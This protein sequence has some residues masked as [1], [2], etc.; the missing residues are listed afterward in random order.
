MRREGTNM[1]DQADVSKSGVSRSVE[2]DPGADQDDPK[3]LSR[4][5]HYGLQPALLFLVIGYWYLNPDSPIVYPLAL[6]FIQF[7]L[8]A[9]EYWR[10]ARPDW[11]HGAGEKV[12]NVA[13]VVLLTF[14]LAVVGG[15]YASV[16]SGPL[17]DAR[18]ALGLDVWPHEWPLLV[19]LFM[20]FFVS[21]LVWY[22]FHRAEHRWHFI[23]RLSGH[24][25]HHS[26][27]KLNAINFGLNHPLEF[28]FLVL[29]SALVELFFGVGL[30]AAGATILT[31]SQASIAHTN[32][33]LNTRGIGWLFTTNKYHITHHSA[34]L[35]E[36]NTNYGC[37][38]IIWDRAFGTFGDRT[39]IE[40]GT[41]PTEPT[42]WEKLIMPV[43]EPTDTSIAP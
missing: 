33:D 11:R 1:N 42:L 38:A 6:L 19:Q 29:P 43:R 32:L 35:E 18:A 23:W 26:F 34:V 37:S 21:E 4:V 5:L 7:T 22:W 40:A 27:K 14:G 41:G 2:G 3:P 9:I 30:A 17:A 28:T 10:P 24:G 20:V 39:I 16:L 25:V 15:F 36:S 13:L 12:L 8:G 31:V